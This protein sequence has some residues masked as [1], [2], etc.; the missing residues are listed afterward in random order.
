MGGQSTFQFKK[1][2]EKMS[3]SESK[4][5]TSLKAFGN[6]MMAPI[7]AHFDQNTKKRKRSMVEQLA[8]RVK[9]KA[10][11]LSTSMRNSHFDNT[12]SVSNSKDTFIKGTFVLYIYKFQIL[13]S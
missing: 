4:I 5:N 3:K 2:V 6:D 13:I 11:V 12:N 7:T 8:G 9:K 10:I 1:I